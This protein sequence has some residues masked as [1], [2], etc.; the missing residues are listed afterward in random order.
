MCCPKNY[1]FKLFHFAPLGVY[2]VHF[3]DISPLGLSFLSEIAAELNCQVSLFG[4]DQRSLFLA[5]REPVAPVTFIA[6]WLLV[7]A[8]S[9]ITWWLWFV[10]KIVGKKIL[11]V[12][13]LEADFVPMVGKFGLLASLPRCCC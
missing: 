4:I 8:L 9:G 7:E 5:T 10:A 11:K 13:V 12:S 1:D 6:V 2:M 3:K